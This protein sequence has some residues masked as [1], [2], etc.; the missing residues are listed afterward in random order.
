[1]VLFGVGPFPWGS[2]HQN[3]PAARGA[4]SRILGFFLDPRLLS[5]GFDSKNYERMFARWRAL[6]PGA[7]S[8]FVCVNARAP[9][10]NIFLRFLA[11]RGKILCALRPLPQN[12]L[13]RPAGNLLSREALSALLLFCFEDDCDNDGSDCHRDRGHPVINFN[14]H[15]LPC[16]FLSA[17]LL[18]YHGCPRFTTYFFLLF[19]E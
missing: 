16:S 6:C 5:F 9:W 17:L 14:D 4:P 12:A 8:P 11:G 2:G 19:S 18:L 7:S 10:R 15:F 3:M 13:E 1:M